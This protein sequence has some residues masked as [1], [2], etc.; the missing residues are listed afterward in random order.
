MVK[1]PLSKRR[2]LLKE[3]FHEVKGQFLFATSL[4][5]NSMEEVQEFLEESIKGKTKMKNLLW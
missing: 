3:H 2:E 4:D 5:T 1:E